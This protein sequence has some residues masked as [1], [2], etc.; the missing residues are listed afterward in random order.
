MASIPWPE[1]FCQGGSSLGVS[2]GG[3]T[4]TWVQRVLIPSLPPSLKLP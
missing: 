3:F 2:Q 1:G 4:V